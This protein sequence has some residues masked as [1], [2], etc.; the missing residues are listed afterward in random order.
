MTTSVTFAPRDRISEK[1][2][3]PGVSMNVTRVPSGAFTCD[4]PMACVIPP[5]SPDATS[6]FRSASSSEVLP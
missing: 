1:A 3:W 5:A 4:A 2:A 6:V